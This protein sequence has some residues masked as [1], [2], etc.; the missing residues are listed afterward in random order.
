VT[1]TALEAPRSRGEGLP[2]GA[3]FRKLKPGPG[4]GPEEVFADQRARLQGAMVEL[5]AEHGYPGVTVRG[6]T[7][8][9]GVSSRTFYK[10]FE[11]AG[12]CFASTY[13]SLMGCGLGRAS[14]SLEAGGDWER[15]VQEG[16]RSVLQGLADHPK[17]GHLALVDSFAAGPAT[18]GQTLAAIREF[19]QLLTATLAAAPGQAAVPHRVVQG[20]VDGAMRVARARL[21]AGRA[22]ELPGIADELGCWIVSLRCA[23]ALGREDRAGPG[24]AERPGEQGQRNG[25][26]VEP[27]KRIGDERG[28]ILSAAARLAAGDGYRAMTVP[29]VRAEAG[30]SR[31]DFDTHFA[32]LD[33][34]FLEAIEALTVAAVARAERRALGARSRAQGVYR[35]TVALCGEIAR[36]SALAQ[37]GFIDIFAPGRAGLMR[38]ERLVGLGA[39]RLRRLPAAENRPSELA[40]EASMAA[41]WRIVQVEIVAGRGRELVQVA[42]LVA[43]V[44]LAPGAVAAEPEPAA[45]QI[46]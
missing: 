17:A 31:R 33:E 23:Y 15:N 40:A 43:H 29:R 38:R 10:H 21:L 42:P 9:A 16:L 27:R 28:R 5:V 19:E 20:M 45:S 22:A 32:D 6:L 3:L 8:A 39:E 13:E 14:T 46:L 12:G 35:A 37:L 7:R 18:Q 25:L 24:D 36:Y 4:H 26:A 1:P 41:A 11:N 2:R 30:V 34:C 44:L